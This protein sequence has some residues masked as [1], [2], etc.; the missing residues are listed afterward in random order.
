MT[1]YATT[2]LFMPWMLIINMYGNLLNEQIDRTEGCVADT[3]AKTYQLVLIISTY[4]CLFVYVVFACSIREVMKRYFVQVYVLREDQIADYI[5]AAEEEDD[6]V[7]NVN[8]MSGHTWKEQKTAFAYAMWCMSGGDSET[9]PSSR[10]EYEFIMSERNRIKFEKMHN[11]M[12]E[13]KFDR[14]ADDE[15]VGNTATYS[16]DDSAASPLLSR[17][18]T[19]ASSTT[20]TRKS[21]G[22]KFSSCTICLCD[23]DKG[24]SVKQVPQCQHTFHSACLETWLVRKF[25]CPNCNLEI[26]LDSTSCNDAIN[27]I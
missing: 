16:L 19:M 14:C 12:K 23:F 2:F 8:A 13:L 3:W 17:S 15:E 18:S 20:E 21:S 7:Y 6:E 27:H 4:C 9:G 26:K 10:D 25:S 24:D 22:F 1:F 5:E 11:T